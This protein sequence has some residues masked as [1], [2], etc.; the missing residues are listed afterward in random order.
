MG[1]E[2]RRRANNTPVIFFTNV[3]KVEPIGSDCVR[4][5]C[6]IATQGDWEDRVILEL[7]MSS[8]LSNSN[9]VVATIL[10]IAEESRQIVA[11]EHEAVH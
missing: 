8:A 6:S 5:Y 4:I 10:E 11:D 7:P 9:F 2:V 3:R 1:M